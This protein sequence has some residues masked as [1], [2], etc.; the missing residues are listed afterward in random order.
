MGGGAGAEGAVVVDRTERRPG[1]EGDDQG[2]RI[3]SSA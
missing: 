2:V 3:D 1:V